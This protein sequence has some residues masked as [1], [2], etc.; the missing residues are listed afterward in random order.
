MLS[1]YSEWHQTSEKKKQDDKLKS[2]YISNY[3]KVKI[4]RQTKKSIY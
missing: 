3:I 4:I 2:G 1:K